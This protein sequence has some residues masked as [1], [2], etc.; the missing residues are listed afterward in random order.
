MA[1]RCAVLG[2]AGL[3][4][5]H[6]PSP[7][8]WGDWFFCFFFCGWPFLPRV[9]DA[10]S[11]ESGPQHPLELKEWVLGLQASRMRGDCWKGFLRPCSQTP[12]GRYKGL[13]SEHNSGAVSHSAGQW[14]GTQSSL[15]LRLAR[16]GPAARFPLLVSQ[17]CPWPFVRTPPDSPINPLYPL[18]TWPPGWGILTKLWFPSASLA[19]GKLLLEAE[20]GPA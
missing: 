11:G 1:L 3:A 7:Q 15:C 5:P 14:A 8:S 17:L 18:P 6:A 2:N 9:K 20:P 16:L 12:G 4:G 13:A 19:R 10:C